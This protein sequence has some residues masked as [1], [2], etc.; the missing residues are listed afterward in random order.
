[1]EKSSEER[2]EPERQ[3]DAARAYAAPSYKRDCTKNISWLDTSDGDTK[4][5]LRIVIPDYIGPHLQRKD[6]LL[7]RIEARHGC[8]LAFVADTESRVSTCEGIKG[9]LV[10]FAGRLPEVLGAMQSL[11]EEVIRTEHELNGK[12]KS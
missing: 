5:K 6:N 2:R 12:R 10:Q 7:G 3:F 4:V 8:K 11:L 9:R 1:M